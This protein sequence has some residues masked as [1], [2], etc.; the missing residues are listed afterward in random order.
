MSCPQAAETAEPHD[1][2]SLDSCKVKRLLFLSSGC[3]Y[4][5]RRSA[6]LCI[7][8]VAEDDV[9]VARPGPEPEPSRAGA[10]THC[11]RPFWHSDG[12]GYFWIQ[13]F[14]VCT[15]AVSLCRPPCY[16]VQD[17]SLD[18]AGPLPAWHQPGVNE[19]IPPAGAVLCHPLP[20]CVYSLARQRQRYSLVSHGAGGEEAVDRVV[21]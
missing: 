21:L 12:W 2:E 19:F 17:R 16:P 9:S 8:K 11:V 4:K 3:W 5:Y 7:Q 10:F 1:N 20:L 13:G 18:G 6:F 15:A 14:V